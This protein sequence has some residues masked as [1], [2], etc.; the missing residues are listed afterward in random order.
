M[1][2]WIMKCVLSWEPKRRRKDRLLFDYDPGWGAGPPGTCSESEGRANMRFFS[3]LVDA[4]PRFCA[5]RVFHVQARKQRMRARMGN[6]NDAQSKMRSARARFIRRPVTLVSSALLVERR[7]LD[8][9]L[10]R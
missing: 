9:S 1:M 2:H 10:I 7:T 5:G 3:A 4:S 6:N 8:S